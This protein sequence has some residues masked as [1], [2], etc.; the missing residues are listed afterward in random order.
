MVH[1]P[2]RSLLLAGLLALEAETASAWSCAYPEMLVR[3]IDEHLTSEEEV[4]RIRSIEISKFIEARQDVD[5]VVFGQFFKNEAS[6][7]LHE[8]QLENIRELYWPPSESTQMPAQI[9]YTYFD[10]YRFEGHQI[11]NGKLVPFADKSIDVR[12]SI[13]AEYEG[14]ADALPLTSRDV[15]GVLRPSQRQNRLEVVA[16]P[17]PTYIPIEPSQLADLLAC[18]S[19][20]DCG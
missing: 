3:P 6:P 15:I 7:F 10:A 9:E 16:S 13:F 18:I 4:L 12:I 8:R 14:M 2:G 17:C 19:D 1:V 20:G 11:L 5:L